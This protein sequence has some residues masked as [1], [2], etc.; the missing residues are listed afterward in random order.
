MD[1]ELLTAISPA[2]VALIVVG[3][4][5]QAFS[6][7]GKWTPLLALGV[8]A[9]IGILVG[10]DDGAVTSVEVIDGAIKGLAATGGHKMLSELAGRK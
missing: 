4:V 2:A 6:L 8:G 10:L 1:P 7:P 5:R 9:V 3:A